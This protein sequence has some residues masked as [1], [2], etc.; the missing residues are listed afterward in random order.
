MEDFTA[1]TDN[2][3]GSQGWDLSFYVLCKEK[4]PKGQKNVSAPNIFKYNYSNESSTVLFCG[5][6]YY[7]VHMS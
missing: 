4:G 3:G 6:V 1:V 2:S 5:T 7:A